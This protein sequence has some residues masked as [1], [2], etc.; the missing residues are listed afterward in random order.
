MFRVLLWKWIHV[1]LQLRYSVYYTY[2]RHVGGTLR[3]S[4][5]TS[6]TVGMLANCLYA[7]RNSQVANNLI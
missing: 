1:W 2:R 6:R 3:C 7:I 5:V 4:S